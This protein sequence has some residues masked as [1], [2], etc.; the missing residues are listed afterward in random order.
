MT[1]MIQNPCFIGQ[2]TRLLNTENKPVVADEEVSGGR[3]RDDGDPE[4]HSHRRS[5]RG[6][7]YIVGNASVTLL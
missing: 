7:K 2:K 4:S 1:R 3:V 6:A 5:P